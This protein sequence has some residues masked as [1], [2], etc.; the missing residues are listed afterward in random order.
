MISTVL[1]DCKMCESEMKLITCNDEVK[2]KKHYL[3]YPDKEQN[4]KN[5]LHDPSDDSR[6]DNHPQYC[7]IQYETLLN[8]TSI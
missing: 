4:V 5:G 8:L 1:S 3:V 7:K 2:F 6:N